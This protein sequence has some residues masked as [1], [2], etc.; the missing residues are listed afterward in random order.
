MDCQ[1][2]S[3]RIRLYPRGHIFYHQTPFP[4]RIVL[5]P[6]HN[7]NSSKYRSSYRD[8]YIVCLVPSYMLLCPIFHMHLEK[9]KK[10]VT[11]YL[12]RVKRIWHLSPMRAAKVQASLR[13]RTVSPEPSLLAYISSESRGT[14]RQKA[15]SQAPLNG[16]ACAKLVMTECSK[17]QIRLTGLIYLAVP[18]SPL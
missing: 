3:L 9:K 8:L 12:D 15:R 13:I 6:Q 7:S 1:H 14:F 5:S 10:N 4:L 16:W 17:T 18:V 11:Y 2:H